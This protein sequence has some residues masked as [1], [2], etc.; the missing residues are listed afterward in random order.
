[1]GPHAVG[2]GRDWPG[3]CCPSPDDHDFTV[4]DLVSAHIDN[5]LDV[6]RGSVDVLAAVIC[7]GAA[8]G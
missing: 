6:D 1:G 8:R 3:R 5:A 4:V 7:G 2:V